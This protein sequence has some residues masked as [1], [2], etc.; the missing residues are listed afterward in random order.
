MND[1]HE[2]IKW[3]NLN[4]NNQDVDSKSNKSVNIGSDKSSNSDQIELK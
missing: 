2:D 3:K 1:V 4:I